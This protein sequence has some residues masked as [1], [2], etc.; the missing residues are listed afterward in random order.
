MG[1]VIDFASA[2]SSSRS[3]A[4][5][6]FNHTEVHNAEVTSFADFTAKLNITQ[7]EEFQ[8]LDNSYSYVPDPDHVPG[9]GDL[10][11]I[12]AFEPAPLAYYQK[13]FAK[14]GL[15]VWNGMLKSEFDV[16]AKLLYQAEAEKSE[17]KIKANINAGQIGEDEKMF[18]LFSMFDEELMAAIGIENPSATPAPEIEEHEAS[19]V[20]SLFKKQ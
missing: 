15:D 4:T 11:F 20:V 6:S 5:Q 17:A 18:M 3:S 16:G 1:T 13:W 19:N 8:L 9:N 14:I 2:K 12:M 7:T 10:D